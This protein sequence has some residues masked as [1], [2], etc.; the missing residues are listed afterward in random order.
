MPYSS[1]LTDKEWVLVEPLFIAKKEQN[2]SHDRGRKGKYLMV[3][4]TNLR[5]VVIGLICSAYLPPY[6]TVFFALQTV[7]FSRSN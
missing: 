3:S 2:L 7:A 1:S 6:S 4:S 5:M